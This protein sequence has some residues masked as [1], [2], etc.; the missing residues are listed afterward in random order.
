MRARCAHKNGEVVVPAGGETGGPRCLAEVYLAAIHS[1]IQKNQRASVTPAL[2]LSSVIHE[3]Q[4]GTRVLQPPRFT[5]PNGLIIPPLTPGCKTKTHYLQILLRLRQLPRDRLTPS[6]TIIYGH[7]ENFC[8]P[9]T[10][11]TGS[12]MPSGRHGRRRRK[13]ISTTLANTSAALRYPIRQR[14]AQQPPSQR[15]RARRPQHNTAYLPLLYP[16]STESQPLPR[17]RNRPSGPVAQR[18]CRAR[19]SP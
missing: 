12:P 7:S 14:T 8:A 11:V 18:D 1:S 4:S 19:L 17:S 5:P 10:R 13:S 2:Y 15:R 9:T 3:S 6:S 16:V